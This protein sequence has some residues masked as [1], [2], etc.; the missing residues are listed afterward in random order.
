MVVSTPHNLPD[1]P[2]GGSTDVTG[3]VRHAQQVVEAVV[4]RTGAVP[5]QTL[6]LVRMGTAVLLADD[7]AGVLYR[8]DDRVGPQRA[9]RQLAVGVAL[10][11]LGVPAICPIGDEPEVVGVNDTC[12]TAW[13]LEHLTDSPIDAG[14]VGELAGR[15]HTASRH[16]AGCDGV[17]TFEPLNAVA[18]Q[19]DACDPEATATA[20]GDLAT[21]RALLPPLAEAW[22]ALGPLATGI[23]HGDLH[24]DNVLATRRGPVL[25]DLELAGVGPVAYDLVAPVVAVER[26]GAAPSTL[27]EYLDAYGGPLPDEARSGPL[28]DTYEL[29]LTSWA[30]ANRTIDAEHEAE[31]RRRM[32]RW[33]DAG[34]RLS[35]WTL[36]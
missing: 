4:R 17:D 10:R 22:A 1:S 15:L 26:Y 19:L 12:V 23:V 21:L 30:V 8:V 7:D 16:G 34:S 3:R 13:Q 36:R 18:S 2:A 20:A 25:A 33:T 29:W 28:R 5:P 35:M 24:T 14:V 31:A 11:R 6:R 32:Q 27:T 9:E